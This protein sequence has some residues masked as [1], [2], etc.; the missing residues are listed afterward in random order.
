[1]VHFFGITIMI[2]ITKYWFYTITEDIYWYISYRNIGKMYNDFLKTNGILSGHS[3]LYNSLII[4]HY[5]N[6]IPVCSM[7][8]YQKIL[9][10]CTRRRNYQTDIPNIVGNDRDQLS[11]HWPRQANSGDMSFTISNP[12]PLHQKRKS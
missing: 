12:S 6:I 2:M 7:T 11:T 3:V 9:L 8:P 5:H 4:Y 1:M 10:P